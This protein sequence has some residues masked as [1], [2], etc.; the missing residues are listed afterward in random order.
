[1]LDTMLHSAQSVRVLKEFV[2]RIANMKTMMI[3]SIVRP[4]IIR[5]VIVTSVVVIG[6]FMRT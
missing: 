1:L 2:M 4:W 3:N 6:S 5:Q